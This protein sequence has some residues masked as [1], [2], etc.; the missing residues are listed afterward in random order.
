MAKSTAQSAIILGG[1]YGGLAAASRLAAHGGFKVTLVDARPAFYERIRLHEVAA[2]RGFR[3]WK[4]A[5]VLAG[6]GIEFLEGRADALD[7][8]RL[9]VDVCTA[10]GGKRTLRACQE[11]TA[12]SGPLV[13]EIVYFHSP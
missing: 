7:P 11:I 12:S 8:G 9:S 2:G 4:Y 1:G 6:L 5:D 3:L 13:G 10:D